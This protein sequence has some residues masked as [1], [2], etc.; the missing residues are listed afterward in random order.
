MRLAWTVPDAD[1]KVATIRSRCLIPAWALQ[2]S[3]HASS[4][5]SEDQPDPSASDALVVVKQAGERLHDV[6]RASQAHDKPVFLDLCDNIFIPGY[7]QRRGPELSAESAGDL[8]RYA[9][10]LV[11]PT[12]ALH[13]LTP[14]HLGAHIATWSVPATPI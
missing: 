13:R 12:H 10:A 1:P 6:A 5:F 7:A 11:T 8:A 3:G 14:N 4:I 9:D 2:Q